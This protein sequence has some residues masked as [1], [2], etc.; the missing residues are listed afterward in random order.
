[1]IL[2]LHARYAMR[3]E[4]TLKHWFNRAER[5]SR[6][7]DSPTFWTMGWKRVSAAGLLAKRRWPSDEALQDLI[8]EHYDV[9]AS[10]VETTLAAMVGRG[11]PGTLQAD[12]RLLF[13]ETDS[14]MRIVVAPLYGANVYSL[15]TAFIP[16]RL[17]TRPSHVTREQADEDD[18]Y[19]D[20][21]E[22]ERAHVRRRS[23]W[24]SYGQ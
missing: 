24:A 19:E 22:I 12:G 5:W 7:C 14:R 18:D 2:H 3:A 17:Q 9:Y 4:K 11:V 13:E 10:I 6:H 21:E 23:R 16:V 8:L 15:V 1:V 20:F